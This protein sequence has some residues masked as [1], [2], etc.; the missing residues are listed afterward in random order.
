[1]II[2]TDDT[3][4]YFKRRLQKEHLYGIELKHISLDFESQ[5]LDDNKKLSD[6]EIGEG[7]TV[8]VGISTPSQTVS[9]RTK[10]YLNFNA[11]PFL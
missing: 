11:V 2:S 6:Y 3:V 5:T 10:S 4:Y 8:D 1:M 9:V 7:D